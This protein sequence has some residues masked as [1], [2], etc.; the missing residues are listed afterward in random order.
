MKAQWN[1]LFQVYPKQKIE[2]IIVND[3]SPDNTKEVLKKLQK[4]YKF[5]IINNPKNLGKVQ[6]VNKAIKKQKKIL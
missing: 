1:S 6:S 4:K 2:L 5:T 3:C